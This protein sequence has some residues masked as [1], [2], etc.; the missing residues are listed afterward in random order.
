MRTEILSNRM[1]CLC[2]MWKSSDCIIP[3]LYA[4]NTAVSLKKRLAN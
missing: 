4:L 1:M 2:M 3:F